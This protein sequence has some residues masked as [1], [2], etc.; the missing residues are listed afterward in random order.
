MHTSP[1]CR[2]I[3]RAYVIP[4]LEKKRKKKKEK[5][6]DRDYIDVILVKSLALTRKYLEIDNDA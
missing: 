4:W 6:Y 3:T 5:T 2:A 1:N